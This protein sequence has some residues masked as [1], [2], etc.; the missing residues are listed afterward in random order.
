MSI[1]NT[2]GTGLLFTGKQLLEVSAHH[3][4]IDDF[5]SPERTDGRHREG[6]KPV[7]R[8]LTDVKPR[9]LTSINIDYKQMG[10]GGDTSWGALTHEKYRLTKNDY[11]Y[12][13]IMKPI[14]E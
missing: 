7:H 4:T 10:V 1:T 14:S 8:H 9:D 3:N 6:I 11:S 5:I 2:E 12:G 13:F